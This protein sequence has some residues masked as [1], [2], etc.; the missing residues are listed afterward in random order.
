[1]H[2]PSVV[3][4]DKRLRLSGV[5]KLQKIPDNALRISGMTPNMSAGFRVIPTIQTFTNVCPEASE[6]L[7]RSRHSS[8]S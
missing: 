3:T 8:L 2:S 1:M 4:Q 7:P 5:F 6:A